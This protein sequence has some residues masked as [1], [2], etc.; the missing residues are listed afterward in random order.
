M[1]HTHTRDTCCLSF[2]CD[3]PSIPPSTPPTYHDHNFFSQKLCTQLRMCLSSLSPM[4]TLFSFTHVGNG[5][6]LP[7]F[8]FIFSY[9]SAINIHML[10][11]HRN[12]HTYTHVT[13]TAL[14][15]GLPPDTPTLNTPNVPHPAA[16]S[17][18]AIPSPGDALTPPETQQQPRY[19]GRQ[20]DID[21]A[22]DEA[23][24][25]TPKPA[26]ACFSM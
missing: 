25:W 17:Y 18:Q 12:T 9:T 7:T 14:P 2:R 24:G 22:D 21:S 19:P 8:P 4:Y 11:T 6:L 13:G 10:H 5:F 23:G 26:S 3:P 1:L 16:A 15:S 20:P